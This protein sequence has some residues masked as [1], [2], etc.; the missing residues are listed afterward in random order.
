MGADS[1]TCMGQET[2]EKQ[3]MIPVL[4]PIWKTESDRVS[5]ETLQSLET[6]CRNCTPITPLECIKSCRVY[7][8]K[9]E[10]R[11]LWQSMDNPNYMK[12][13]LNV[14]KNETRVHI[15]QAIAIRRYSMSE[16]QQELK[17]A[18]H[19]HSQENISKEYLRP[20]IGVGLVT[21][22]QDEYYTTTFSRRITERLGC[23]PEF[24]NKLPASSEC[25]EE[26]LLQ[27]LLSGPKTFEE[28]KA[29][30]PTKEVSRTLRRLRSVRLIRTP[31]DRSYIFFFKSK[32]DPNKDNL[33]D[34]E[35]RVYDA[36]T[37][38]GISAGNLARKTGLCMRITYRYVRRLKGKKLVF[39]R[40]TPKVYGLTC[41]G[42]KLVQVI[43]ELQ[44]IVEA[45]WNSSQ[46]VMQ[47]S[48]PA[49]EV[50]SLS[51]NEFFR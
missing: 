27:N 20:L 7:K 5:L 21:A 35:K 11:Q 18:G 28:I 49:A 15:L 12:E 34:T 43:R 47:E 40:R 25:Y 2:E 6:E 4:Q 41:K 39:T 44:Q 22:T 8:L 13:L 16:L 24:A 38:E 10:L 37:Y 3:K 33:A 32:R 17:K 36:V 26:S 51:S 45:A 14:L 1:F 30:M 46:Q 31:K 19:R 23:F 9:N 29:I 48:E 50:R 42:R